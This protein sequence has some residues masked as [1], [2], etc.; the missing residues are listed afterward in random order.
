V[1]ATQPLEHDRMRIYTPTLSALTANPRG[2]E[3]E[4]SSPSSHEETSTTPTAMRPDDRGSHDE[5]KFGLPVAVLSVLMA[6]AAWRRK[7]PLQVSTPL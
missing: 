7:R 6:I 2:L 5:R 3:D 1:D 4:P